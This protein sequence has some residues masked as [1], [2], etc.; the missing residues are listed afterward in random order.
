M[1]ESSFHGRAS[2]SVGRELTASLTTTITVFEY[3]W[4]R[5]AW[6]WRS[7][8]VLLSIITVV[9]A[10]ALQPRRTNN[11]LAEA[12]L[13]WRLCTPSRRLLVAE[14]ISSLGPTSW[15]QERRN[16]E[17]VYINFVLTC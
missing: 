3:H 4:H 6:L 17:E 7:F 14:A 8:S 5:F 15:L 11:F 9:N 13:R 12:Q 16:N 10:F 1:A 2:E